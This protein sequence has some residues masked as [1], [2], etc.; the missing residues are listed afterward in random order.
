MEKKL[1][2]GLEDDQRYIA[3][4]NKSSRKISKLGLSWDPFTQI[5]ECMS[6]KFTESFVSWRVIMQNLKGNWLVISKL[7]WGFD[8]FW[9]KHTQASNICTLRGSFRRKYLMFELKTYKQVMFFGTKDW[10]K[11]WRKTDL[12]FP[13]WHEEFG[14]FSLAEK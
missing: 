11:N 3:S 5:W 10:C 4:F 6:L 9:S 7:A 12:C 1:T 14:K 8:K 13:K 2:Y